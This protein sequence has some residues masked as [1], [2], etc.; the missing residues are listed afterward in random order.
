MIKYRL[1]AL[2]SILTWSAF[3]QRIV[4]NTFTP[5]HVQASKTNFYIVPPD[6][7][8]RAVGFSGFTNPSLS[9][10]LIFH[11]IELPLDA[12]HKQMSTRELSG[13]GL[14]FLKEDQV[15]INGSNGFLVKASY[16]RAG[17]KWLRYTLIVDGDVNLPKMTH[18]VQCNFPDD[19]KLSI[20]IETS[21][22]SFVY[23]V[24]AEKPSIEP[25]KIQYSKFGLNWK[26]STSAGN[27]YEG[28]DASG[29]VVTLHVS[30]VWITSNSAEKNMIL[31]DKIK[32]LP[33]S[34]TK[35]GEQGIEEV[36]IDDLPGFQAL[37]TAFREDDRQEYVYMLMLVNGE[38]H[39][40]FTAT[41]LN[42]KVLE[43]A[44]AALQSF[45]R[46]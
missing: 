36:T 31:Y 37:I 38:S 7:F 19:R 43:I 14:K 2:F 40:I 5:A 34:F 18:V 44:K 24:L 32:Q 22:L 1:I 21:I 25:F 11:I 4:T 46:K 27:T 41:S 23:K 26:E 6:G 35:L 33:Y 10:D 9:A 15:I 39:Y 3:C 16:L 12:V 13:Q 30:M 29:N 28:R 17:A 45:K 8:V 20:A 42:E